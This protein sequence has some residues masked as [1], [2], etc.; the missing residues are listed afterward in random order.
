MCVCVCVEVSG[1]GGRLERER[2]G[3]GREREC[4]YG[5]TCIS[6]G[7]HA[8]VGACALILQNNSR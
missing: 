7:V 8:C 4:M 5:H 3:G 2:E 6:V 1:G